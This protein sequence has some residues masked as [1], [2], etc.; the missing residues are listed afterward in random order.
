MQ[1]LKN[2]S[3]YTQ[4]LMPD[5]T[6]ILEGTTLSCPNCRAIA[7]FLS[8][9]QQKYPDA[10]WYEYNVDEAEDI[11]QELGVRQVPSFTVFKDGMLVEGVTGAGKVNENKLEGAIRECYEGVVVE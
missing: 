1:T 10:R 4:A 3:E 11:A 8:R 2:R 7:P 5:G 9:M 6:I